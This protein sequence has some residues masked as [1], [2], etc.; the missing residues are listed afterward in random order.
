MAKDINEVKLEGRA[1]R[2]AETKTFQNGGQIVTFSMATERRWKDKKTDEWK[3]IT[4]WHTV[5]VTHDPDL[6]GAAQCIKKGS[7]VSLAGSITTR[8]YEKSGEKR[9]AFEISVSYGGALEIMD[10][11]RKPTQS[12]QSSDVLDDDI[13]F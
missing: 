6:I 5:A 10:D 8:E 4:T 2:D 11:G 1:G 7:R 9:T 12:A 13:P 3:G